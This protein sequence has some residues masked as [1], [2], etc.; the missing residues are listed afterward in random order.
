MARTLARVTAEDHMYVKTG[1]ADGTWK[2]SS[3]GVMDVPGP[4]SWECMPMSVI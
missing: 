1:M 4:I 2:G 3:A